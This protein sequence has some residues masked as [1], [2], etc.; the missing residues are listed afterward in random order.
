MRN[1]DGVSCVGTPID[2]GITEVTAKYSQNFVI[3]CSY[4]NYP[5][6]AC[7]MRD[8]ESTKSYARVWVGSSTYIALNQVVDLPIGH[9]CE[10]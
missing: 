1:I 2:Q 3:V 7:N 5:L 10:S 4:K 8:S 9:V 6:Y